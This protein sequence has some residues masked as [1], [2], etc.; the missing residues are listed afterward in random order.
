MFTKKPISDA[1]AS[2]SVM[3]ALSAENRDAVN[4]MT[5]AAGKA[6]GVADVNPRQDHGFMLGRSFEDPD[7]HM[8]EI[9][10]MDPNAMPTGG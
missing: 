10:W 7:G 1:H 5:E 6:G 4:V 8:W 3:L 9:V 2:G